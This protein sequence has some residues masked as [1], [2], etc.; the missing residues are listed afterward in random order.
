MKKPE[1]ALALLVNFLLYLRPSEIHRLRVQDVVPPVAKGK[2]SFRH[3]ALLLHP[4]EMG[5]PSK[6]KQ[7]DEMISLDLA[8]LQF[9]GPAMVGVLKLK[10]RPKT[11]LAFQVTM[12]EVDQFMVKQWKTLGFTALGEPSLYRLRHGGASYEAANR[13]REMTAI[14][15]RGRWQAVKSM[16]NY[17]KGGRLQQLFASLSDDVQRKCTEASRRVP[18]M[19]LNRP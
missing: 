8:H 14:Q 9:L 12:A 17:E 7:W 10:T 18:S 5:V 16:K 19:F 4:A 15:T 2:G 11:D 1:I 6:T 13:L 3:Y